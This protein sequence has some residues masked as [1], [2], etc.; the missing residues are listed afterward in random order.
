MTLNKGDA[1]LDGNMNG[2]FY[3]RRMS[4]VLAAQ[5]AEARMR[6]SRI[7]TMLRDGRREGAEKESLLA[8]AR[9]LTR[10]VLMAE[11]ALRDIAG[12]TLR[13]VAEGATREAGEARAE[14]AAADADARRA[15]RELLA[16][17]AHHHA[18]L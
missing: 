10:E 7:E 8:E 15:E 12:D 3:Q 4:R 5:V 2:A 13:H 18:C 1:I 9:S 17:E 6:L 11:M 14:L 16:G